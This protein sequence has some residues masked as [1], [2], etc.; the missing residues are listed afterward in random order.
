VVLLRDGW[1][2][3]SRA[4]A[5][6]VWWPCIRA[7]HWFYFKQIPRWVA[8]REPLLAGVK[9]E[10]DFRFE[11]HRIDRLVVGSPDDCIAAI[12]EL[13]DALRMDYL[14]MSFRMAAGP[15][16]EQE[17][18]CIRRFGRDVIPAFR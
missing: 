10:S 5:E 3:D 17:L 13:R 6:R 1:V 9:E 2:A 11:T 14:I 15:A 12:S 4:E 16:H 7:E 8:D 18:E